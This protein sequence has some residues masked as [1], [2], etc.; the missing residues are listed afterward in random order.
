M[1]IA[2]LVHRIW[3]GEPETWTAPF[4]STWERPGWTLVQWG[5]EE[6]ADLFPLHNQRIYDDAEK[7]APNHVGQLRADV[8]RYE[9]LHRIG[10]VYV[11]ADFEC[12]KPID[13]LLEGVECFA[14][15]EVEKKWVNNA[16][17]GAVAGH[18]FVEGLIEGLAASVIRNHGRKPNRMSGPQYVTKQWRVHGEGVTIFPQR[19]FYPYGFSEVASNRPGDYYANAYAV[20]HWANRRRERGIPV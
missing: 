3:L 7:F 14:A 4:A 17:M 13:D 15:W 12:L 19:L 20:H 5:E 10:G 11:D 2:K 6:V 8:L 18:P 1:P 16:V 9:I